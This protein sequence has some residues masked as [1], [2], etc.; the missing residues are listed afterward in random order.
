M[1]FDD[2]ILSIYKTVDVSKPGMKPEIQ[3]ELKD[4]YYF[5]F[6]NIGITRYYTAMQANQQISA[7][8]NIPDWGDISTLDICA[9]EDGKQYKIAMRQPTTDENGLRITKLSLERMDEQYA[10]KTENNPGNSADSN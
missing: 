1:T 7:V 10:V 8:V 2:G 4:Q 5:G 3:L 9:L 6:D